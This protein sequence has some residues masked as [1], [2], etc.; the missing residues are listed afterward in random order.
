MSFDGTWTFVMKAAKA[1]GVLVV[2]DQKITG[3]DS[4]F[5]YTGTVH[6]NGNEIEATV[7][8][9]RFNFEQQPLV[10]AFGDSATRLDFKFQG[11]QE[12]DRMQ[13]KITRIGQTPGTFDVI[14]QRHAPTS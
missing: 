11:K 7:H 2:R 6:E 12:N 3:G 14:L 1:G 4:A 10:T 8:A 9:E 5:V 13:G